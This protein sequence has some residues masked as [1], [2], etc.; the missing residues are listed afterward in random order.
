MIWVEISHQSGTIT[1]V[2]LHVSVFNY[3]FLGNQ[4]SIRELII[5]KVS[6]AS[7]NT[8]FKRTFYFRKWTIKRDYTMKDQNNLKIPAPKKMIKSRSMGTLLFIETKSKDQPEWQIMNC[9]WPNRLNCPAKEK[10]KH[11]LWD[12]AHR[13]MKDALFKNVTWSFTTLINSNNNKRKKE[14]NERGF[15]LRKVSVGNRAILI[16]GWGDFQGRLVCS[17]IRL[18]SGF[19]FSLL[20]LLA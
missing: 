3:V 9:W 20:E 11:K 18:S 2:I 7:R 19:W 6:W 4:T 1:H 5:L 17:D 14:G 16:S 10:R 12:P 8:P 13:K 15:V